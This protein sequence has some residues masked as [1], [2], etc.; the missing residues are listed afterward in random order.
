MYCAKVTG[1]SGEDVLRFYEFERVRSIFYQI[2]FW[3]DK[4]RLMTQV[5]ITNP[6]D[7][8][9]PMYWWSN[10]ATPEYE[11]G[12][13]IVNAQSAYNNSDGLGVKSQAYSMIKALMFPI[14]RISLQLLIISTVYPMSQINL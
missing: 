7:K 3:L 6:N 9:V 1:K 11:G 12:R 8:V 5:R 2:D 14:R 13:V 10:M 4:N